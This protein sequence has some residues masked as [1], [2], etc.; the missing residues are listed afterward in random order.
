MKKIGLI[1]LLPLLLYSAFGYYI[2][3]AYLHQNARIDYLEHLPDEAYQV[4]SYKLSD[5]TIRIHDTDFDWV[6]TELTLEGKSYHIIKKR[7]TDNTLQLYY[8]PN[9]KQ[10]DL[11]QTLNN[12]VDSQTLSKSSS[13]DSPIKTFLKIFL[14]D[15]IAND[16]SFISLNNTPT[17]ILNIKGNTTDKGII[18]PYISLQFPPPK[19]I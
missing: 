7:I 11:R 19:M 12:I 5:Y 16:V 6:D 9:H 14:K 1:L 15:Y 8:L 18:S 10:D 13:S 4:L 17:F 3:F 2:L